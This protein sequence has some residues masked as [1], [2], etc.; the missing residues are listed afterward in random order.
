VSTQTDGTTGSHAFTA[1]LATRDIG[2][3]MGSLAPMLSLLERIGA[4]IAR[5]RGSR[6]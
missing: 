5:G 2:A 1:A 6:P 3:P 4:W